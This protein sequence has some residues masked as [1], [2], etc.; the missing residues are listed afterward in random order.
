MS[1]C[2]LVWLSWLPLTRACSFLVAS[3]DIDDAQLNAS[4][5]Y[6]QR[7]G[8]DVT[9][10]VRA[11]GWTFVHNLLSM[12]GAVTLQPFVSKSVVAIFN[13]E[14]YNYRELAFQLAGSPEAFE[15]D[16]YSLLPAYARWG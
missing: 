12:T 10:V 7:R 15:S 9:N 13:G 14:I 6:N 16:G 2:Q 8:P 5:Y 3:F 11:K 1:R 4:N